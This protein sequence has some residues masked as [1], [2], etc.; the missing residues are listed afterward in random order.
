MDYRKGKRDGR[1]GDLPAKAP[2]ANPYVPYQPERGPKYEEGKAFV[3]GTLYPGLDLPFHAMV[4]RKELPDTP[5]TQLQAIEFVILELSLYLDTH[6]ENK[7][8]L[9]LYRKYQQ[10]YDAAKKQYT[11]N[12][13]PLCHMNPSEDTKYTWISDPWPW[14]YAANKED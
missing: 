12:I 6:P 14:E 1:L 3:R 4:N 9:H 13:R 5:G 10:M 8:A 2:L 7:E 11:K